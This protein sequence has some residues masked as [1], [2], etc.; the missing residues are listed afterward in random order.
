MKLDRHVTDRKLR[1]IFFA[2]TVVY[3]DI[4]NYFQPDLLFISEANK[5]ILTDE[6]IVEGVPDL[7]IEILSP[8]TGKMI[9]VKRCKPTNFTVFKNTGLLI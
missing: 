3:L 4:N 2:P 6:G 7:V 8:S 1:E 5:N 9:E